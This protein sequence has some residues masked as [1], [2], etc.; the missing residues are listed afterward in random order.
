VFDLLNSF[1]THS[2]KSGSWLL[3]Q[4]YALTKSKHLIRQNLNLGGACTP[5]NINHAGKG[6]VCK[7][8]RFNGHCQGEDQVAEA[9]P[10]HGRCS[11]HRR[12]GRSSGCR[13]DSS[14][15]ELASHCRSQMNGADLCRNYASHPHSLPRPATKK[16]E[17]KFNVFASFYP[18]CTT[19]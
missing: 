7:M 1:S 16:D 5:G 8:H 2:C 13:W 4:K 11:L 6:L 19:M 10:P 18:A 14:L 3:K 12:P 17:S 9:R 15:G